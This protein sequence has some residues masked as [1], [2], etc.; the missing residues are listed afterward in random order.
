MINYIKNY[1]KT[2]IFKI[3]KIKFNLKS[4]NIYFIILK[5]I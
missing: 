4:I 2:I 1:C 3:I 5:I